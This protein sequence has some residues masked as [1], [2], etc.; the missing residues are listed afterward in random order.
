M[1]SSDS[2]PESVVLRPSWHATAAI[3]PIVALVL[4][5][6][7]LLFGDSVA[8][9][10]VYAA[11]FAL[12]FGFIDQR[13]TVELNHDEAA[14]HDLWRHRSIARTEV[15][16]VARGQWWNG[17]LRLSTDSK[18]FWLRVGDQPFGRVSDQRLAVVADWAA[19]TNTN[20]P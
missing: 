5:P 12:V 16:G 13:R 15:R 1:A 18:D 9:A 8:R 19:T 10:V 2:D 20:L 14:A 17:G 7:A 11:V 6:L 4:I 3:G